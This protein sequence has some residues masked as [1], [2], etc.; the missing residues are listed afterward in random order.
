LLAPTASR[1]SHVA[2][3]GPRRSGSNDYACHDLFVPVEHTF[4]LAEP[5][6]RSGPLHTI[7]GG[8][9]TN[10]QWP[11][12]VFARVAHADDANVTRSGVA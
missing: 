6:R 3:D 8:F 2:H 12:A 7:P 4:S 10:M 9:L 5:V 1:S 11:V